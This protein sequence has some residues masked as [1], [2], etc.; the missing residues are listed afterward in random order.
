MNYYQF[1][2]CREPI[3]KSPMRSRSLDNAIV[4]IV[5]RLGNKDKEEWEVRVKE[6]AKFVEEVSI[7]Y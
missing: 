6:Q 1:K 4:K 5:S 2:V 3:V 7:Y